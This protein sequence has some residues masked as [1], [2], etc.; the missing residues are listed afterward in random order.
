M[1]AVKPHPSGQVRKRARCCRPATNRLTATPFLDS[2]I[3][4]GNAITGGMSDN[5]AGMTAAR[6]ALL[7]S[8]AVACGLVSPAVGD[9]AGGARLVMRAFSGVAPGEGDDGGAVSF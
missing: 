2:T 1:T 5:Q 3:G 8:V 4:R 7:A 9:P 6:W